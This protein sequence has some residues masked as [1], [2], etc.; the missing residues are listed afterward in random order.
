MA[1]QPRQPLRDLLSVSF[2]QDAQC[3]AVGVAN[4]FRVHTSE[5]CAESVSKEL[6]AALGRSEL[7][8]CASNVS[9]C[10][11]STCLVC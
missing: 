1:L 9:S 6:R 8:V 4:G 11:I 10:F 7:S 2:N 3:F 5:P